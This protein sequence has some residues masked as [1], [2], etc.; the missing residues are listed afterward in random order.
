MN[1]P[2]SKPVK[3]S[4]SQTVSRFENRENIPMRAED[5][6]EKNEEL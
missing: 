2:V 6:E 5:E 1:P 3:L 4:V